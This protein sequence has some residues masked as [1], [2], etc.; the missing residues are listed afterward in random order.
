[1]KTTDDRRAQFDAE[2]RVAGLSLAARDAELLYAMWLEGL[3]ERDR[4]PPARPPAGARPRRWSARSPGG[5]ARRAAVR[6]AF[7]ARG[8]AR[9]RGRP[10]PRPPVSAPARSAPTRAARS[11]D[12]PR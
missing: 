10:A 1:M 5:H 12:R 4:L 9:R 2:C 7:S 3:P 8:G 6:G 11:G